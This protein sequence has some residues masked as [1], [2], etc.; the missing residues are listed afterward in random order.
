MMVLLAFQEGASKH[1]LSEADNSPSF[2]RSRSNCMLVTIS[3]P[4]S[5]RGRVFTGNC[6]DSWGQR[7]MPGIHSAV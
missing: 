2:A 1:S 5:V 3:V 4:V 6:C 7:K